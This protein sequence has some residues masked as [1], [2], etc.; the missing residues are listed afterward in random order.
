MYRGVGEQAVGGDVGRGARCGVY[1]FLQVVTATG[2]AVA[3]VAAA[4]RICSRS[5]VWVPRGSELLRVVIG[6]MIV[7]AA[8]EPVDRCCKLAMIT[9]HQ[10][11]LL[12]WPGA[13]G[14]ITT[15]HQSSLLK[16]RKVGVATELKV[17]VLA[18]QHH[19]NTASKIGCCHEVLSPK[20]LGPAHRH[21]Q[22]GGSMATTRRGAA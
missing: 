20:Q 5:G 3:G 6:G 2:G 10:S 12:R 7:V 1:G 8:L 9:A 14:T 19:S 18:Q 13:A 11:S 4:N 22:E 16:R 15:A 21:H 17:G